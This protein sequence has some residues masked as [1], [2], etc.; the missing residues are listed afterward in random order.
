MGYCSAVVGGW[1]FYSDYCS[2]AGSVLSY[3]VSKQ[4]P[5]VGRWNWLDTVV[6][7]LINDI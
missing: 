3:Y 4:C 1:D 7:C 5:A 2:A 6:Q